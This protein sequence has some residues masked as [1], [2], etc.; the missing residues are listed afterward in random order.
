MRRPAIRKAPPPQFNFIGFRDGWYQLRAI[1]SEHVLENTV[2]EWLIEENITIGQWSWVGNGSVYPDRPKL[3]TAADGSQ[4]AVVLKRPADVIR[5]EMRFPCLGITPESML[6]A[7]RAEATKTRLTVEDI[8]R[9]AYDANMQI[10]ILTGIDYP[11]WDDFESYERT[12]FIDG[13][14][15]QIEQP[16]RT[17]EQIHQ[18]W[19]DDRIRD[20]WQY[21]LIRNHQLKTHP[22]IVPFADLTLVEKVKDTLFANI[23][24]SLLPLLDD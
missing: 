12:L 5:F 10:N 18:S 4:F 22:S 17:A 2:V 1:V 11:A 20:G 23:V 6:A 8:A 14:R 21:G 7:L 19:V 16:D 15:Q 9:V 24:A 3:P 13:V